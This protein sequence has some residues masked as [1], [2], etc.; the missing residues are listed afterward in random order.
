MTA[1]ISIVTLGVRDLDRAILFYETGL[2]FERVP[3]ESN[4]I[5]FLDAGGI[6]LALY[7]WDALAEDAMVDAAG[8][9]FRGVTLAQNLE[10]SMDVVALIGRAV[11]AG[12]KLVKAPQPVFWG[13]FSGYFADPDGHLWEVA[14]GSAE[15]AKEQAVV[16]NNVKP[17]LD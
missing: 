10:S 12:G 16:A 1:R 9:G 6:Q 17:E 13:G 2:G 14:C 7:P 3:H 5:A 8:D 4:K 15:Y 11:E